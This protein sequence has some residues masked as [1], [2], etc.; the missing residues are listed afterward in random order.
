MTPADLRFLADESCDFAV[1]R[2]LRAKG[3]DVTAVSEYTRRS[4]DSELIKQAHRENRI[5]LTEDKDFGWLVFASHSVSAGVILIRFP[6]NAR[7]KLG[8]SV[9]E[10]VEQKGGELKEA[11]VVI[12]PGQVRF[13]R[14]EK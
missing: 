14:K 8:L 1:V 2:A 11:F 7:I 10:L 4:V 12:Q 6:G 5:L 13:S 3:Y 9:V